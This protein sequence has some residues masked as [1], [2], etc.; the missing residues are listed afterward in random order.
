MAAGSGSLWKVYLSASG[1]TADLIKPSRGAVNAAIVENRHSSKQYLQL[2][3]QPT[4][5]ESGDAP[6]IVVPL[7]ADGGGFVLEQSLWGD[8]GLAFPEG[9]S[10]GVSSTVETYTAG[11]NNVLVQILWF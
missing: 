3:N 4:A 10:W 6:Y 9:I 2:F 1:K 8:N 7:P 5:P 11:N